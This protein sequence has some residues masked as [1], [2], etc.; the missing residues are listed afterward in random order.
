MTTVANE[1]FQLYSQVSGQPVQR[2][3]RDQ[4]ARRKPLWA[5]PKNNQTGLLTPLCRCL[6][7]GEGGE[8]GKSEPPS[9]KRN[10][11]ALNVAKLLKKN[12]SRHN[13]LAAAN[14]ES[15]AASPH[16]GMNGHAAAAAASTSSSSAPHENANRDPHASAEQESSNSDHPSESVNPKHNRKKGGC[17]L[18]TVTE[19]TNGDAETEER[20]RCVFVLFLGEIITVIITVLVS[21]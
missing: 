16:A 4:G 19:E 2:I 20:Y 1:F 12:I 15:P 21:Y 18:G 6:S 13:L 3:S 5:F 8:E 9:L 10:N 14:A 7:E 11:S 17:S